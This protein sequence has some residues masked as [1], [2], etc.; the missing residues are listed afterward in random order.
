MVDLNKYRELFISEAREILSGFQSQLIR[1][2]RGEG[3]AEAVHEMFRGA[4][5]LKGMAASMGYEDFAALAHA[6]EDLASGA[7]D[8]GHLSTEA[9]DLLLEGADALE[10]AVT[11]LVQGAE[12]ATCQCP[13]LIER[14]RAWVKDNRKGKKN[15]T[16]AVATSA[17]AKVSSPASGAATGPKGNPAA[18]QQRW[19]VRFSPEAKAPQVRAFM[20][21][22]ELEKSLT[23][24]DMQ[25]NLADLRAGHFPDRRLLLIVQGDDAGIKNGLQLAK[26]FTDVIEV[27][28]PSP[29]PSAEKKAEA[30]PERRDVAGRVVRVRA[31][32]LDEF[33]DSVGELLRARDRLRQLSQR[34]DL[35]ELYD[36]SDELISL[37]KDLHDKVMMARMTPLSVLTERLP[38]VVRDLS[39]RDGRTVELQIEGA[40]IE[41]DRAL[42]DELHSTLLHIV[43]NAV[44]HGHEGIKQRRHAGK[45][46]ALVVAVRA[47]RLRDQVLI[48]VEDDG[49]GMDP[50][51]IAAAA[52][53]KGL[54]DQAGAAS[55]SDS[56][57]LALICTPGFS[58]ASEVTDVSGR[59]VGMD[60][61]R[62]SLTRLGGDLQIR[63][64]LGVGTRF[65]LRLPLTMAII[66]VMIVEAGG[67]RFAIPTNRISHAR[68][69]FASELSA[70]MAEQILRIDGEMH[71]FFDLAQLLGYPAG[72]LQGGTVVLVEDSG[73]LSALRVERIVGMQDVVVKPLGEPLAKLDFLAGA[74]LLGGGEPVFILDIGRLVRRWAVVSKLALSARG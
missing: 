23:V 1:F 63:S 34:L 17:P 18:G 49:R 27:K 11:A 21:H 45:S 61:V 19:V 71:H 44:D 56:E 6:L 70:N 7:R 42:I 25:P 67:E 60:A 68:D 43:R 62:T 51:A 9:I 10:A 40:E 50:K 39:R 35:P 16:Y 58:T 72:V 28:L 20:L 57:A 26:S 8:D 59:G 55:L 48:D 3:G 41:M 12:E 5:S 46:E 64:K 31:E 65:T 2:E 54:L 14:V 38:R 30:K 4:H 24:V 69:F 36:I 22:R 13:D 33:I 37:T 52:I 66:G 73:I 29:A 74:A 47:R 53:E 32:I 15:A